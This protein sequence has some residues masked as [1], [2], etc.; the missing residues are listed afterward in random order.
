MDDEEDI[1]E[2]LLALKEI[3]EIDSISFD[4]MIARISED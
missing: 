1:E 3:E 2:A 4:E